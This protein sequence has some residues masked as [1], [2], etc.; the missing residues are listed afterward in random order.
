MIIMANQY[1][2]LGNWFEYLN[3]DCDYDSWSQYL[4][5][6]LAELQ[7]GRTGID[8][9]C[10]NGTFTRAFCKAG[11]QVTGF[12]I[13][14]EMLSTA[15]QLAA[16]KGVHTEF[17]LGDITKLKI[18]GKVDFAT[19][20][21][22][23]LNYVSPQNLSK[24]FTHV[25]GCLKKGGYFLFDISSAQKL[26]QTLGNNLFA[27]DRDELTYLWFN[28]CDGEK[29]EMDLSFFIPQKNGT[30][31]RQDEHHTQY[32]H[33]EEAV[34]QTLNACGFTVLKVEGH[35]GQEKSDRINFI[36]KKV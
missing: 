22:D 23:C 12:D 1:S 25:A 30:Y 8:I 35:L 21:N 31:L 7:V 16:E 14:A 10:G 20:I 33:H 9:G 27:E 29:V 13:S 18:N 6:N 32:V 2:A 3:A 4:L 36:C 26:T 17:L 15:R 24:A 34:I 19:A 28:S 11:Y 5:S